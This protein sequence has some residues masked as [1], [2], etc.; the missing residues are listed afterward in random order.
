MHSSVSHT[1]GVREITSTGGIRDAQGATEEVGLQL[2]YVLRHRLLRGHAGD[3][4]Q[5]QDRMRVPGGK[6]RRRQAQGVRDDHVVVRQAVDQ[7]QGRGTVPV[8]A[9]AGETVFAAGGT[10]DRSARDIE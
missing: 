6:Q 2:E 7:E 4:G 9:S 1:I 3:A 10:T 8:P 5:G